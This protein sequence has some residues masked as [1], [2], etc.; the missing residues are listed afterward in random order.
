MRTWWMVAIC[1]DQVLSIS[2]SSEELQFWHIYLSFPWAMQRRCQTC[3]SAGSFCRC[4]FCLVGPI[5]LGDWFLFGCPSLFQKCLPA[6]K[7]LWSRMR[8][9]LLHRFQSCNDTHHLSLASAWD[10]LSSSKFSTSNKISRPS[11]FKLQLRIHGK[12]LSYRELT[13]IGNLLP[14]EWWSRSTMSY[15]QI[16]IAAHQ[17]YTLM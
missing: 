5:H 7:S 11:T 12:N 4:L 16:V 3:S 14:Y 13:K 17:A 8:S 6:S 15:L 10:S 9:F 2:H 1:V